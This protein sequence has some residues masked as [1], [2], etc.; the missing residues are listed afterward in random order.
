MRRL[1]A[2]QQTHMSKPGHHTVLPEWHLR[3]YFGDG[4]FENYDLQDRKWKSVGP[5]SFGK[6]TAYY[7]DEIESELGKIESNARDRVIKLAQRCTLEDEE[8]EQVAWYIAASLFRNSALFTELLPDITE[9][10]G[11][12]MDELT[13]DE[14]LQREAHGAWLDHAPQFRLIAENIH[15]LSWRTCFVARK[16]NY[17]LLTDRPFLVRFPAHPTQAELTFPISSEVMLYIHHD[18]DRR[19][20]SESIERKDVIAHGRKLI[21]KANR[22]IAAP[23]QDENLLRMIERL[24]PA[25][26][27]SSA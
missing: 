21:A 24:R 16:P 18:G 15:D 9:S 12:S 27:S 8:R 4:G 14:S 25:G 7:E 17:L 10:T 19:W 6:I 3:L 23:K 26:T 2:A 1:G 20:H 11:I 5:R 13:S 22:F